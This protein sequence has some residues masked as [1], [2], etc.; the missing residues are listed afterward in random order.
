MHKSV[1]N[2]KE[3]NVRWC[4][5]AISIPRDQNRGH[6]ATS[7]LSCSNKNGNHAVALTVL[8]RLLVKDPFL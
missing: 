2:N 8:S 7:P 4:S 3:L 5:K 1:L 6:S